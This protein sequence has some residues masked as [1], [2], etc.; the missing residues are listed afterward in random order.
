MLTIFN[1][2][3]LCRLARSLGGLEL[4]TVGGRSSFRISCIDNELVFIPSSE[5]VRKLSAVLLDDFLKIWNQTNSLTTTSYPSKIVVRS[6]LLGVLKYLTE[7][8]IDINYSQF[9]DGGAVVNEFERRIESSARLGQGVF[10]S[11]LFD[12]WGGC[13]VTG[14][15]LE[16]FLIASHIKPWSESIGG[17]KVDPFNGLLLT[18]NL[19]KLFDLGLISFD[20]DGAGL[21]SSRLEGITPYD[22]GIPVD[23]KMRKVDSNNLR[24]LSWHRLRYGFDF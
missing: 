8:G 9:E 14:V 5:D 6:Y 22:L 19:D 15:K 18:P 16:Q 3:H 4:P 7:N 20:A 11:K 13:S 1:A 10:R 2:D 23:F 21:I 17:E 12:F 24:Y